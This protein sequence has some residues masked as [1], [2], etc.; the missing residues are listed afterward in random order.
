MP[1]L[2]PD[3]V[4]RRMIEYIQDSGTKYY[5]FAHQCN[6]PYYI[7]SAWKNKRKELWKKSLDS[8]DTYLKKQGY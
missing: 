4:R 3:E 5:F 7:I 8:I 2:N 1:K 6:V